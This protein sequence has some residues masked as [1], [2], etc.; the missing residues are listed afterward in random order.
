MVDAIQE[1]RRRQVFVLITSSAPG[2]TSPLAVRS[3]QLSNA[4]P[5]STRSI[6]MQFSTGQTRKQRLQPTQWS[7]STRGIRSR[8]VTALLRPTPP[9]SSLGIGVVEMLLAD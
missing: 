5:L 9:A 7:S 2:G 6:V 4:N 3:S 1:A 8:G